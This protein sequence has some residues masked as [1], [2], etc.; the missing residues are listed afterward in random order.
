MSAAPPASRAETLTRARPLL[1]TVVEVGVEGLAAPDAQ[2]AIEQALAEIGQVHTCM[3]FQSPDSELTGLNR[4]AWRKPVAVSQRLWD[5]LQAAQTVSQASDGL[6]DVTVAPALVASGY[7]PAHPGLACSQ[8]GATL[9][10][11]RDVRLLPQRRV[12]FA[13]PLCI[14]LSGIA[15]GYAVDR[16]LAILRGRGASGG[17][18]NAGGDLRCFGDAARPVHVRHPA[19]PGMLLP[20]LDLSE[21]AVAT[22]AHYFTRRRDGEHVVTALIHPRRGVSLNE[23]VS[24]TVLADTCMLADALTKVVHADQE[25]ALH[26]LA[27]FGADALLVRHD[28]DTG[29]CR[30]F[31]MRGPA[32]AVH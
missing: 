3:S 5:V 32:E 18:V 16:A 24:V 15:K 8:A 6:F 2:S 30:V 27:R 28:A 26:I 12:Q 23:D 10:S 31:D 7:L 22:S 29:E 13:R 4:H 1:G 9:A 14:D 11:W 19:A 25:A 20:L 21:G 17:V